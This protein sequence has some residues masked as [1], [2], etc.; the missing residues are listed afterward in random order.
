MH[1]SLLMLK[2]CRNLFWRFL[3]FTARVCA[4]RSLITRSS[5]SLLYHPPS[6]HSQSFLTSRQTSVL[7]HST[8]R[9]SFTRSLCH[10]G[11]CSGLMELKEVLQVLEQ[12]APLS[13]AE[14]WDNVGLLVEPSKPRP[15]KTILLTNDLTEAVM[16]EAENMNCDLLISYHPPLFRPV[17]RLVQKDWKQRLAIRAV[18]AG[19]A[20]FSPHTS[21]DSVKG[22][23]N[24]WLVG[25]LGSGRVSVLNQAIA[26]AS[27]N[28]K[29]E[30]MVRSTEELNSI[31]EEVKACD[32]GTTLHYSV[33][34]SDSC[35]IHVS[36]T[37]SDSA[38]TPSV[39]TLLKHT[40]TSQS[41]RILKLEK[42]PLLGHGQGRFSVLDNPVTIAT[43][44]QKIKSHLGLS[45]I[46]LA[47]GVGKTPESSVWTVAVCAGSG[48]SVLNGVKADLYLTGE[49][50]HHEVL[51][52]VAKGTSVILTD[53]SN[54]E[55]GF[56]SVFRERLAVR[57]PETVT[58]VVS[59][60]DR[61]PLE[62]V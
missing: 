40:G 58:V 23:V 29:L 30:F 24:D 26:D 59:A 11:H 46:R 53:H 22:G 15:T 56:L 10:S 55:R 12:L 49:M 17:K 52:A 51:D 6:T 16:E 37:C 1:K 50:S 39:Q 9:F 45:H 5:A 60:H 42:P 14:S 48:A 3:P 31:L 28:H 8:V 38:L 32:S 4:R 21:W 57:L 25:G 13:L 27:H 35:G 61:D 47:L 7:Q 54:S 36:V 62:V 34:R 33:N 19:I 41:L 20:V 18:E 43:A 44:I 2:G